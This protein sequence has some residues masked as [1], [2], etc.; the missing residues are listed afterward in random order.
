MVGVDMRKIYHFHPVE[1][2]PSPENLPTGGD[3]YYECTECSDVVNSVTRI[4]AACACGNL[5]GNGGKTTVKDPT[6]VRVVRGK[7]K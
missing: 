7:L 4:K 6:K 2:A 3:L 5:N 1:P